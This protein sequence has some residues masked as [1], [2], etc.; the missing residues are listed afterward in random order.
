MS[1]LPFPGSPLCAVGLLP[2]ATNVS[3]NSSVIDAA[4]EAVILI[5]RIQTSD[6]GSHTIDTTGSSSLQWQTGSVTFSSTSTTVK[7]GLAAVDTAN[8]PPGR[9]V[10]VSN[11]I[12]FD[13]S[14]TMT[15][16][17]GGITAFAWQT[18]V[19]DAG[20]KT[21][22]NGDLV[23]F[24]VQMTA[25]GGSDSVTVNALLLNNPMNRPLVTQF[26]TVYSAIASAPNAV[27]SFS[28]GALG[29]FYGGFVFRTI[30]TTTFNSGSTPN[31]RGQL[32]QL[33]F[34]C[35]V[36]G[37]YVFAQ[38]GTTN[39]DL[40]L[41]LYS[42]PLGTPVA[43]RTVSVDQNTIATAGSSQRIVEYFSSGYDVPANTPVV[44]AV[45]PTTTNNVTLPFKTL[46]NAA[47]RITDIW[48]TSGYGVN[49]SSGAFAQQN[50]GL[51]HYFI[52]LLI[53]AFEHPA[54]A[55]YQLGI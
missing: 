48:G 18:H 24:A 2:Y 43:Q 51:D 37:C 54:R 21:I 9:A 33:P 12:T 11:V 19:P 26:T 38:L 28:D 29:F 15:G 46:A 27:I 1:L 52:G 7:V 50:S 6:G 32:F 25:R 39:A 47:H 22:A 14:R 20:S 8:G 3:V 49:R 5:G 44:L 42:D 13:V 41:I 53:E 23:A 31:E 16:G 36:R 10:N 45:K 34:P 55:R 30:S 35:R 40:D 4:N 17:G